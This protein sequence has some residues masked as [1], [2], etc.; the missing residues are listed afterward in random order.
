[1]KPN[2]HYVRQQALDYAVKHHGGQSHAAE[3]V[4][5]AEIFTTFLGVPEFTDDA[6]GASQAGEST[7]DAPEF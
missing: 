1:M 6:D 3:V 2:E 7:D 5:T 4:K